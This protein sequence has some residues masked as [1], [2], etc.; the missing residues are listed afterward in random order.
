MN[1]KLF[2]TLKRILKILKYKK[3]A[4]E[5]NKDVYKNSLCIYLKLSYKAFKNN[6]FL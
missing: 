4:K 3:K 1:N 6:I 2:T 5:R